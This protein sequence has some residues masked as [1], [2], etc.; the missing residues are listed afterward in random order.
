MGVMRNKVTPERKFQVKPPRKPGQ[1]Y[2]KLNSSVHLIDGDGSFCFDYLNS[3]FRSMHRYFF[4]WM[5]YG[6]LAGIGRVSLA[7]ETHT[8]V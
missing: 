4:D 5:G 8:M 6:L 3:R 7:P 1:I 2:V